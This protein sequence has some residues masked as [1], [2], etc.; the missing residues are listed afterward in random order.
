MNCRKLLDADL[1][2]LLYIKLVR[3]VFETTIK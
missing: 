3:N 2:V 1:A